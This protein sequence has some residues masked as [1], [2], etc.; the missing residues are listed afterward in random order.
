MNSSTSSRRSFLLNA[1]GGVTTLWL[2][3]HG[4]AIAETAHHAQSVAD[5]DIP[6]ALKFFSAAD[7][8]DVEAI[9]SCIIPSSTT[10]GA[11]EARVVIF[12]DHAL[13]SFFADQA[14]QFRQGLAQFQSSFKSQYPATPSFAQANEA[15]QI[16][17]LETMDDSPF[18]N[19]MIFMTLMGFLASPKYG[20]NANKLGWNA[21]GFQDQHLFIPPFGYYDR[22]Y[23]GFKPYTKEQ[24]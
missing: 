4:K 15:E 19:G 1:A 13:G 14:S 17:F 8:A 22:D 12:I 16:A 6:K 18:F 7:G 21:I 20:G 24:A 2:A 9:A 10:A 5:A 3:T 23:P 11:R